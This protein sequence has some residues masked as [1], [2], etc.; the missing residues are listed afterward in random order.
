MELRLRLGEEDGRAFQEF[1][2][3]DLARGNGPEGLNVM[4]QPSTRASGGFGMTIPPEVIVMLGAGGT[5]VIT[6]LGTALGKQVGDYLWGKLREFFAERESSRTAPREVEAR[7]DDE[8]ALIDPHQ[9]TDEP[10][11]IFTRL[12]TSSHRR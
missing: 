12:N 3:R 11:E 5:G 9:A 4:F 8:R 7:V 2:E 10:P 1:L 6:G